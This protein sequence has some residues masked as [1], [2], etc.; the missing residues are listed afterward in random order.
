MTGSRSIVSIAVIASL[1]AVAAV[2]Q[3]ANLGQFFGR[4]AF[5]GK[6]LHHQLRRGSAERPVHQI[7]DELTLRLL[8]RQPRMVD[9]GPVGLVAAD[10]A[11]FRHDLEKLERG[12]IGGRALPAEHLV[13]LTDRAGSAIPEHT[14]DGE[15]GVGRS[16]R[17]LV[18]WRILCTNVF[19]LST[20]IFVDIYWSFQTEVPYCSPAHTHCST[21]PRDRSRSSSSTRRP[22]IRWP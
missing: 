11:F 19:V 15:L 7:A 13:H 8:L 16:G 22:P 17:L 6:R 2:N 4:R 9:V 3:F 21:R 12:G 10:E 14:Q 5:G 20:K 1:P 18:H